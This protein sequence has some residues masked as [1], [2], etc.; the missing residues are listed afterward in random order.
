[1]TRRAPDDPAPR[2]GH[3][4]GRTSVKP[5]ARST[6]D[7]PAM[8]GMAILSRSWIPDGRVLADA[9][10]RAAAALPAALVFSAVHAVALAA[11]VV[12]TYALREVDFTPRANR[13]FATFFIGGA[14]G[15]LLAWTAAA[16]LIA[17]RPATARFAGMLVALAAATPVGCTAIY[18]LEYRRY[19]ADFHDGILSLGYLVHLVFTMA[20]SAFTFA[21]S[22]LPLILPWGLLPLFGG[23]LAFARWSRPAG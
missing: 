4:E 17:D 19:Y 8:P 20:G 12:A 14:L 1:M 10:R 2:T 15:G 3:A 6:G 7:D 5:G 23:A 22:G 9:G 18:F 16:V 13:V 11:I 21:A